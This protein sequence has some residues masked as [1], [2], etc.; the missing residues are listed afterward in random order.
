MVSEEKIVA[1][2]ENKFQKP[3]ELKM[4]WVF[5]A[6][7]LVF[8][9]FLKAYADLATQKF[10][11]GGM[12]YN[13]RDG[14]FFELFLLIF[15]SFFL[16]DKVE[17]PSDLYNWLYFCLLLIP[18]AVLSA[19]Q[20]SDRYY[21]FLMFFAFWL[22]IAF[23]RIFELVSFRQIIPDEM[24]F[25]RLPYYSVFVF[26]IAILIFL[27]VYVRGAFNLDFDLVYE[28]RFDISDNMP[29]VLKY[30]MPL[31][32]GTLIGYLA[33]QSF[34][35]RDI[36]GMFL[37]IITGVLFF[38]FSSHKSMLFNPL[39]AMT[40]YFLL[41][42]LRPHLLIMLGLSVLAIITLALPDDK[43]TLLGNLFVNRTMFIPSQ[44]NFTYFDFFDKHSFMLWAESKISMGLVKTE[45]PMPVMYHIGEIMTGDSAI[46]ANTGWVANA[47][48]NAGIIGIVI[49]AAIIGL[50]FAAIDF[51]AKVYGKQLV[52]A[53]F[54]VPVIAL[55]L[56]ADLLIVLL[57]SGLFVLLMLFHIT[58]LR[59]R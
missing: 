4:L 10:N 29:I 19:G 7:I 56:S 42:M 26:I 15:T 59:I 51:W 53:A 17:N 52:G 32:S 2:F 18:S 54:L 41:M 47:Y 49:Y 13:P 20:G 21:L 39:V 34:H 58:T 57:T 55:M 1:W 31:A 9:I 48:M 36:N 38:G 14:V 27:V 33:A 30:L 50:I 37:I 28:F 44:I 43:N 25:R 5:L 11:F 6:I 46:S 22:L 8:F 24:N 23:R 35:R 16:P 45:L 40:G 12:T 3:I